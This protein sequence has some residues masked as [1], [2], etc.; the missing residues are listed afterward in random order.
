ML[1]LAVEAETEN[2]GSG[3]WR[4]R[5]MPPTSAG[6]GRTAAAP[7]RRSASGSRSVQVVGPQDTGRLGRL[8]PAYLVGTDA[9][10]QL[11]EA[12]VL[13]VLEVGRVDHGDS[14][15]A[16]RTRSP[17]VRCPEGL[18]WPLQPTATSPC[19]AAASTRTRGVREDAALRCRNGASARSTRR[20]AARILLG[21]LMERCL[22]TLQ[23]I[24]EISSRPGHD[25]VSLFMD[26]MTPRGVR[27]EDWAAA[28]I[29]RC[30]P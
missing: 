19:A 23:G 24:D 27:H 29:G 13:E 1:P 30:C 28:T 3:A 17:G 21:S 14:G 15:S 20:A 22:C 16:A 9:G 2:D 7:M 4:Q 6:T 8:G 10:L 12:H 5:L 11:R 25:Y 26:L 18:H